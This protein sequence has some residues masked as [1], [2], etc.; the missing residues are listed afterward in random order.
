MKSTLIGGLFAI[1]SAFVG[2]LWPS[3]PIGSY[4]KNL[5]NI[6]WGFIYGFGWYISAMLSG[7]NPRNP[8]A[9]SFGSMVWPILVMAIIVYA[10]RFLSKIQNPTRTVIMSFLFLSL[11]VV[12][13]QRL[14]AGSFLASIPT[15]YGIL[16]RVY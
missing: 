13:P 8:Q 14:I 7:G 5:I 15:Y 12:V 9:Q 1:M 11:F 16:I 2:C 10:A 4:G 3:I 6:I